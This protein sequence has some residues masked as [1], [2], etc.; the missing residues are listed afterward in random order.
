MITEKTPPMEFEKVREKFPNYSLMNAGPI[1]PCLG[2]TSLNKAIA[3]K[4]IILTKYLIQIMGR[5]DINK[6]CDQNRK[7]PLSSAIVYHYMFNLSK[8]E[9]SFELIHQLVLAGAD[10]NL[11]TEKT[12]KD[13]YFYPLKDGLKNAD[14]KVVKLLLN[15]G[16]KKQYRFTQDKNALVK[17]KF[18][19]KEDKIYK[20][21]KKEIKTTRYQFISGHQDSGSLISWFPKEIVALIIKCEYDFTQTPYFERIM[22]AKKQIS[23]AL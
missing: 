13:F 7:T 19:E 2:G 9:E 14:I 15:F 16:A 21:V 12:N 5:K 3:K 23:S 18:E 10:V 20:A 8:N 17:D 6:L 22:K 11:S 4:N 1:G